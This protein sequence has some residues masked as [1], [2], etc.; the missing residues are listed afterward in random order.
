MHIVFLTTEYPGITKQSGGIA[1]YTRKISQKL[2]TLGHEI[3]IIVSGKSDYVKNEGKINI[4][5]FKSLDYWKG[6]DGNLLA[7][8]LRIIRIAINSYR[9]Y[10]K[11]KNLNKKAKIDVVQSSNY[12]SP[13]LFLDNQKCPVI[14][15][16]SSYAPLL[17]ETYGKK[18]NIV[19]KI[20]DI[21]ELLCVRKAFGV[22]SP[23]KLMK[24]LYS[25]KLKKEI[26]VIK[27]PIDE[28]LT[29]SQTRS[30]KEIPEELRNHR[31]IAYFGSLSRLKGVDLIADI[32]LEI[33]KKYKDVVFLFVGKDY[34]IPDYGTVEKYIHDRIGEE[35]ERVIIKNHLDREILF[36]LIKNAYCCLFPSRIDNLPNACIEAISLGIP[37]IGANKSSLEEMVIDGETG[38]IFENS[39]SKELKNKIEEIL[40]LP[41]S[42]YQG[43]KKNV[44]ILYK[45]ILSE[46]RTQALITYYK[47]TLNEFKQEK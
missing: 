29:N 32:A 7:Q 8:N 30:V 20:E 17:R 33:L 25:P 47:K 42:E 1:E 16:L 22:I 9:F 38:Y 23:S 34:G 2:V 41:F 12:L 45:N 24:N 39:E 19:N 11:V 40:D 21:L 6:I 27:T 31:V 37:I 44:N 13:I 5:S 3:S 14:C 18:S 35:K 15:R 26:I 46:N 10:R 43:M 36:P 4:I 28:S